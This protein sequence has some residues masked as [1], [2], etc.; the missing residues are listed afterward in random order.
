MHNVPS[1]GDK[2]YEGNLLKV[3]SLRTRNGVTDRDRSK[4]VFQI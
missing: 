1:V 4:I 3:K 2:C